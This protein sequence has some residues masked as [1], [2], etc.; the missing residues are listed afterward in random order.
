LKF[1]V[2]KRV[3]TGISLQRARRRSDQVILPYS[4]CFKGLDN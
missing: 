3:K 2:V 4:R 1:A